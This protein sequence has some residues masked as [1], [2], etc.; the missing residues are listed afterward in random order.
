MYPKITFY[1][2]CSN[3]TTFTTQTSHGSLSNV[4]LFPF[5]PS[6]VHFR[7]LFFFGMLSIVLSADLHIGSFLSSF[8]GFPS[9]ISRVSVLMPQPKEQ[10]VHLSGCLFQACLHAFSSETAYAVLF[11]SKK[12]KEQEK[13]K[14]S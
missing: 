8:R 12:R 14:Q 7:S 4:P 1:N 11:R 10:H 3:I 5:E 6:I 9:T 13:L 2:W